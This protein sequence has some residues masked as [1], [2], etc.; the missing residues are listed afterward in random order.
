LTRT[1]GKNSKLIPQQW[2][3]N[4]VQSTFLNVMKIPHFGRHQ[5]VNAYVKLLLESYHGGY[6]WLDR[7]ITVDPAL[8]NRITRL[9]MQGLDPHEYYSGKTADHALAQKIKEAYG[10]VE[11]G[12]RG[13]KVAS[14]ES[15]IVRLTCQLIAGKLVGKN[16]PTQVSIFV[17]DLVGKCVEGLQMN[18]VKYLVNQLEI[19]CREAHDQGHEFHFRWLLIL[20]AFV[21]WDLPEGATFLDLDPFEP[22]AAK[23]S[24]LW[25]SNDMSKQWQSN[26]FFHV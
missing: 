22:L 1:K 5:E 10:D 20:I 3:M 18:W 13:H 19:D 9:S 7:R 6:L 25:Y 24:T 16:R 21:A 12:A 15:G 11:K 26:F 23:F 8:I 2:K 14:I 17:V 4:L